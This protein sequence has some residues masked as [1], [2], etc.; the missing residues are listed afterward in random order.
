MEAYRGSGDIALLFLNLGTRWR[1]MVNFM[2]WQLY[3]YEKKPGA[4]W[5][6]GLVELRASLDVF[7]KRKISY[8]YRDSFTMA[9]R[10]QTPAW[11]RIYKQSPVMSQMQEKN[12]LIK[13]RNS[14]FCAI[15]FQVWWQCMCSTCTSTPL[16]A[17]RMCLVLAQKDNFNMV[18]LC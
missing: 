1:W 2:L 10:V 14:A 9:A 7:M 8:P 3:P 18:I 16:Y 17:L 4:H 13:E 5:K 15:S 6:V 11:G 12:A